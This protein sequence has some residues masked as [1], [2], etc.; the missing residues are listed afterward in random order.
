M[1]NRAVNL[2]IK[3]PY[4]LVG[5]PFHLFVCRVGTPAARVNTYITTIKDGPGTGKGQWSPVIK[6]L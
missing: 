5:R 6:R 1:D 4:I 2:S 3:V